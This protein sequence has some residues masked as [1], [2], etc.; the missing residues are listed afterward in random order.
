MVFALYYNFYF[1]FSEKS[2]AANFGMVTPYGTLNDGNMTIVEY[3]YEDTDQ[4]ESDS[5]DEI[6]EPVEPKGVPKKHMPTKK[7]NP[8]ASSPKEK[9]WHI[10]LVINNTVKSLAEADNF[11]SLIRKHF[12]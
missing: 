3:N 10:K 12:G 6:V 8:N 11:T 5:E 4:S 1:V 9:G 7:Q 2:K